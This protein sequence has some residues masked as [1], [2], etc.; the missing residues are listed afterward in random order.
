M[1]YL[2]SLGIRLNLYVDDFLIA[3]ALARF[4]DHTDLVIDTLLDLG[5]RVNFEKSELEGARTIEYLGYLLDSSGN[6]P[7]IKISHKRVLRLKRQIRA[8]LK[9]GFV[10]VRTLA[11]SAGLCISTAFAVSPGKLFLNMI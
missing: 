10:P 9:K 6:F 4:R 1:T 2:R 3:A 5:L 11:K 8:V 7:I